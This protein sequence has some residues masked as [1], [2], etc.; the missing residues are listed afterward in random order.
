MIPGVDYEE[1][2]CP[3]CGGTTPPAEHV[4]CLMMLGDGVEIWWQDE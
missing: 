3:I 4:A 2:C 1:A